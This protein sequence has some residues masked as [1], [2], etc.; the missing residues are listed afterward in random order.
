M[1]HLTALDDLRRPTPT[2]VTQ[3]G[4]ICIMA[5]ILVVE[6]YAPNQRL[7]S[8]VLEHNGHA[9][10]SAQDGKQALSC[11]ET[12]PI[13]L[14]VTDLTMPVMDGLA[15]TREVRRNERLNKL[16]IIIV[17]ASAREQDFA[18]AA[19]EGVDTLLTK[20]VDS[21]ELVREVG[22]LINRIAPIEPVIDRVRQ[23]A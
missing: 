18:R 4:G 11:L 10:V 13:D 7:M 12:T 17:T 22:R 16:P 9:V 6:D 21:E 3:Y 19:G 5:T 23:A 20:P 14:I 8:F 2:L 1:V 15:L